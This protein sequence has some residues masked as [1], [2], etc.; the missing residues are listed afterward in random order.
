[1]KAVLL[2]LNGLIGGFLVFTY[3]VLASIV[4]Q[5]LIEKKEEV[6]R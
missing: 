5:E 6:N 4:E 1:M 3:H 2:E